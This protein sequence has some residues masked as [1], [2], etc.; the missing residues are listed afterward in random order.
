[1]E[2]VRSG[3]A[4][5]CWAFP[6]VMLNVY[7]GYMDTNVVLPLGPES[8]RVVYHFYFAGGDERERIAASIAVSDQIQ[9]EDGWICEMVQ[10]GLGSRS[11]ETGRYSVRRETAVHAFHCLLARHLRATLSGAG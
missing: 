10:H 8:C 11:F 9:A 1:V 6:N 5:Y 4:F 3:E 2:R 7:H